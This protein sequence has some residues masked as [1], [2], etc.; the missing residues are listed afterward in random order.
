MRQERDFSTTIL[1]PCKNEKGNI[2]PAIKR[3]PEFGSHQGIIF[4]EGGSTDGT[5]E[6]IERVIQAYPEKDIK[7]IVQDGVG[8]GDAVRKGFSEAT[9]DIL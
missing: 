8:K 1:I 4:V 3:L 2:E 5:K 7:L 6:E 9:G